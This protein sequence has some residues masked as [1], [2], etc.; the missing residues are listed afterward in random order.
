MSQQLGF[1]LLPCFLLQKKTFYK[2]SIVAPAGSVWQIVIT[3]G[4]F[5]MGARMAFAEGQLGEITFLDYRSQNPGKQHGQCE[6]KSTKAA[7]P[8]TILN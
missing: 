5:C 4:L 6:S 8:N 7:L 2:L 3:A 1:M